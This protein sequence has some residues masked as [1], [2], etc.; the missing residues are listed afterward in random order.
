MV[1]A[2]ELTKT[3]YR[4][5]EVAKMIGVTTRTVQTY[6]RKG[7]L[8]EVMNNDHAR[9]I[10]RE[11]VVKYLDERGLY[12]DD[13]SLRRDIVYARVST[14]KQKKRGDLDR[15]VQDVVMY[16][17]SKNPVGLTVIQDVG[18]G[19]NDKRK[20]ILKL[21]DMVENDEVL[22]VFVNYRDRLTRFGFNYLET[23]F[24]KHNTEII[25]VSNDENNKTVSE[26]LAED[27]ISIIHSFSGKLYGMRLKLR[28]DIYDELSKGE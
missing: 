27:I 19:L 25:I 16:A 8:D 21:I 14:G 7:V 5:G 13:S 11:S 24:S 17:S 20:G 2:S 1:K 28:D 26:E 4:S 6:C 23:V 18:S 12:F 22:R 3:H 10:P 9:L 15:Q